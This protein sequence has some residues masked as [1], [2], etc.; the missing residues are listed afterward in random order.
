MQDFWSFPGKLGFLSETRPTSL[1]RSC[2]DESVGWSTAIDMWGVGSR[3]LSDP[4]SILNTLV[5][6][7]SEDGEVVTDRHTFPFGT[8]SFCMVVMPTGHISIR[9]W[10][11]CGILTVDVFG[12]HPGG[13]KL[14]VLRTHF[15]PEALHYTETKRGSA[16][17]EAAARKASQKKI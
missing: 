14:G 10:P 16:D 6:A 11:E 12:V 13:K 3:A 2:A 1:S 4:K 5:R 7:A 8:G 17:K 9:T 15:R